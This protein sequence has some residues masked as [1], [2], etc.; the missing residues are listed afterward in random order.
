MGFFDSIKNLSQDHETSEI[1][2]NE[3]LEINF[4]DPSGIQKLYSFVLDILK[5]ENIKKNF[6]E[7]LIWQNQ[8]YEPEPFMKYECMDSNF[9][10]MGNLSVEARVYLDSQLDYY[11]S[12]SCFLKLG[13]KIDE[14]W[15][16]FEFYYQLDENKKIQTIPKK[17]KKYFLE[18]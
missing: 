17:F 7:I 13:L 5:K 15:L 2:K 3:I 14:N 9:I 12:G 18:A 1:T 8:I 6:P 10:A 4:F 16:S 11:S